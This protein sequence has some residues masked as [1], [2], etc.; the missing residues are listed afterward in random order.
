[1]DAWLGTVAHVVVA[2]TLPTMKNALFSIFSGGVVATG[3]LDPDYS[4]S[5]PQ[6]CARWGVSHYIL[7]GTAGTVAGLCMNAWKRNL[8]SL[9]RAAGWLTLAN[10]LLAAAV[11]YPSGYL[12]MVPA[13]IGMLLCTRRPSQGSK[14]DHRSLVEKV[15][16]AQNISLYMKGVA[17]AH[18]AYGLSIPP[19]WRAMSEALSAGVWGTSELHGL[20]DYFTAQGRLGPVWGAAHYLFV[21]VVWWYTASTIQDWAA[22]RKRLRRSTPVLMIAGGCTL[23]CMVPSGGYWLL[24]PT[25]LSLLGATP[26][27]DAP[28][29]KA[30]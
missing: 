8:P 22:R 26:D 13:G 5:S 3:G 12:L 10:S 25:G 28:L 24:V 23:G 27:Q 11:L 16:C 1:M 6:Q 2:S 4:F 7:V 19:F 18:T 20:L 21:G 29:N 14:G 9:P 17:I 15:C 30:E